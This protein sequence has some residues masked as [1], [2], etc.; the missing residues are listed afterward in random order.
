[1]AGA[2]EAAAELGPISNRFHMR[3][4][5]L[6]VDMIGSFRAE[7]PDK[8]VR[9]VV[10]VVRVIAFVELEEP[11]PPYLRID[12]CNRSCLERRQL[13]DGGERPVES[14]GSTKLQKSVL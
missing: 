5:R 8:P 13:L 12:A 2:E 6:H 7:P 3:P 9:S 1:V 14:A 4:Y 11:L 10:E